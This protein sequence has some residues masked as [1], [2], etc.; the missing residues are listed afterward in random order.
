MVCFESF[1]GVYAEGSG[2]VKQ[3]SRT[4]EGVGLSS[5]SI[6]ECGDVLTPSYDR[7]SV[8]QL[9]GRGS[10][11]GSIHVVIPVQVRTSLYFLLCATMA[12]WVAE[13]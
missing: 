11:N 8:P 4:K 1:D 9:P 10:E 2:L 7:A 5:A 6:R 13:M 3:W 12:V